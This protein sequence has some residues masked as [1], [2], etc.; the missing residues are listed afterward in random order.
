MVPRALRLVAGALEQAAPWIGETAGEPSWVPTL[1][2]FIDGVADRPVR[3]LGDRTP[4]E[5][6]SLP[7][8]RP[9][10][11]RRAPAASPI[12]SSARASPDTAAGSARALRSAA[13]RRSSADRSR[14][15]ASGSSSAR[16]RRRAARQLRHARRRGPGRWIA[17]PAGSATA[18]PSWRRRSTASEVEDGEGAP[19]R[20]LRARRHRASTG[21][22]AARRGA[23]VGDPGQR[24]GRGLAPGDAAGTAPEGRRRRR[25]AAHR[26]GRC[27]ASRAR[28]REVLRDHPRQPEAASS[29]G[30]RSPTSSSPAAPAGCIA[31]AWS[32]PADGRCG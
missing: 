20:G 26:R 15:S 1:C 31:S 21:D 17:A 2:L 19:G 3:V 8:A 32:R 9:P 14:R 23:V 28:A 22:R 7:D 30:C 5:A 12:R 6:A 25:G 16:D 24:S 27:A 29:T 10:G 4:L 18:P 13:E 11:A